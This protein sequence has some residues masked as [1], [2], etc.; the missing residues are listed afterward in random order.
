MHADDP[1]TILKRDVL[2]RVTI[3]KAQREALLDQFERSGLMGKPFAKLVGLNYQTFACWIQKRRRA[4]GD[5]S[6]DGAA[7]VLSAGAVKAP[8]SLRLIEAVAT[9]FHATLRG[10]PV[11]GAEPLELILPGGAKLLVA[12]SAQVALAAQLIHS[13]RTPC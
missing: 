11:R 3:T 1:T 8:G 7:K 4:R 6:T 9:P 13:L 5:Y 10:D 2:G 12:S